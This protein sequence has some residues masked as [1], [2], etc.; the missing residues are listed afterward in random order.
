MV[1]GKLQGLHTYGAEVT[2]DWIIIYFDRHELER[3][4]TPPEFKTPMYMVADLAISNKDDQESPKEMRISH[5]A[6]YAPSADSHS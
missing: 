4:K 6:A 5:V 1:N 2:P 3:I